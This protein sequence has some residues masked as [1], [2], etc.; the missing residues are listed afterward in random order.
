MPMATLYRWEYD[1]RGAQYR[2]VCA[3]HARLC[4]RSVNARTEYSYNGLNQVGRKS[5]RACQR[6]RTG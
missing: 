1:L 5:A 6:A 3:W 2:R 4:S